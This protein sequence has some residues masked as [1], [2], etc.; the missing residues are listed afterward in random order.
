MDALPNVVHGHQMKGGENEW[1]RI[2]PLPCLARPV[3]LMGNQAR[4]KHLLPKS[5]KVA[6]SGASQASITAN[7]RNKKILED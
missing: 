5:K 1:Q 3:S 2:Y 6:I 7:S 4:P